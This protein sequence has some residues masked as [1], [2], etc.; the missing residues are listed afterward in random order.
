MYDAQVHG[1]P[2][3]P[4]GDK[5]GRARCF[6]D[7]IYIYIYIYIHIYIYIYICICICICIYICMYVCIYIYIKKLLKG[8]QILALFNELCVFF[9]YIYIYKYLYIYLLYFIY[10]YIYIYTDISVETTKWIVESNMQVFVW[11]LKKFLQKG[12]FE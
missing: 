12:V 2:Q 8:R 11:S 5:A 10:I 4:C 6:H 3:S 9:S 7:Y 1:L